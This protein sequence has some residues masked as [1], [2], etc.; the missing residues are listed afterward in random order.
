MLR[1]YPQVLVIEDDHF[2]ALSTSPY[3]RVTPDESPRWALVRSVAKFLGPDLRV[4]LVA[5][6]ETTAARLHQRLGPGTTWVSHLLQ[7]AVCRLLEDP[8]TD[9]L[10][11]EATM[12]YATRRRLLAQRGDGL[13]VWMDLDVR[14]DALAARG[15]RVRSAAD[16][17]IGPT[18]RRSI[19]VTTATL[20]A[21]RAA[22]FMEDL[23]ACSL[24]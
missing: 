9:K 14:I 15:W 17:A 24:D 1:R 18:P 13:N 6:D 16:F 4:A 2:W 19:R 20:T 7:H 11:R 5:A 21:D 8:R 23:Q 22:A 10:R 3:H 12:A